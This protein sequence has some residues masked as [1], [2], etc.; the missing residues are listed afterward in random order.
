MKTS[1][2]SIFN[3]G[4]YAAHVSLVLFVLRITVGVLMLTHGYPKLK[5]LFGDDPIQFADPIGLGYTASL[6]LAVFAEFLCS[7]LLIIGLATRLS[8]IPLLVTMLVA[9]FIVHASD[10]L[11]VK[12]LALLYS[13]SYLVLAFTGA[14]KYSADYLIYKNR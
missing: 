3:P 10:P 7:V 6:V 8:A 11:N 14:G 4:N 5:M 13:T 12:E 9:A 2:K 1:G